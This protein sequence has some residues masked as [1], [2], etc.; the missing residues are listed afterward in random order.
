MKK[1]YLGL[2]GL[3]V[4]LL[5][6]WTNPATSQTVAEYTIP[7]VGIPITPT[8]I[9]IQWGASPNAQRCWLFRKEKDESDWTFGGEFGDPNVTAYQDTILEGVY[10]EYMIA[11]NFTNTNNQTNQV[12]F[13]FL[14]TGINYLKP[15]F[16]GQVI[17]VEDSLSTVGL[18]P[19][20]DR[21]IDDLHG[22]G[23]C[24]KRLKCNGSL[25]NP[26]AI[27]TRIQTLYNAAPDEV[28]TVVLLGRVPVPYSGDINP[29]AHAD[30][31]GA[32][33][34]D[35]YYGDMTGTWTDNTVN[36]I[37]AA[38]P[39]NRN[40]PG[41]GKF[42]PSNYPDSI[43]LGVGRID[44]ANMPLFGT[45]QDLLRRYLNKNHDYRHRIIN[46]VRRALVD[47]NF[48]ML[49]GEM[50][51]AGT[52]RSFVSLMPNNV[53]TGDFFPTLATTPH[54][55][56][57]GSGGGSYT[58]AGG[59]GTSTDFNTQTPQSVFTFLFG[60]YFGD[61]DSP[62][63]NFLRAPLASNGWGLASIWAGRPYTVLHHMG[64]GDEI[65]YSLRMPQRYT[66]A[67]SPYQLTLIT[68][69]A[70]M[71]HIGL[72]GDPTLRMHTVA[73]PTNVVATLQD[74]N[75]RVRLNW[76]ASVD[77][78][79]AGYI[80]F[81][82]DPATGCYDLISG[83]Q[84]LTQT[85]FVDSFPNACQNNK[86]MVRVAKLELLTGRWFNWSQG[87][88]GS[89][90][91][92]GQPVTIIANP[93]TPICAG[94][95]VQLTA[96]GATTYSWM[97]GSLTGATIPVNPT[98]TTTYTVVGTSGNCTSSATITVTV[99]NAP[100]LTN[101]TSNS[102]VCEGQSIDFVIMGCTNCNSFSWSGPGGFTSTV[103]NATRANVLPTHS[104]NYTVTITGAGGC[105][106][107]G[108]VSVTVT[109]R[110]T[111]NVTGTPSLTIC[112]GQTTQLLA[113][114]ATSYTWLPATGLSSTTIANPV[115]NPT[116][117]T[118]YTV[119]GTTGNC[120]NTT[121]VTVTI[122]S[123]LNI[124]ANASPGQTI[125]VGQSTTLT[126]SGGTTYTWMPGNL[127]GGTVNVSPTSTTTYTVVGNTAGCTGTATI[128]ITVNNGLTVNVTANPGLT[129][130]PNGSTTLTATG[131]TEYV[132]TPPTGLSSTTIANPVAN[133][134]STT[135]YTVVGNTGGC[136]GTAVVT[137]TV[138]AGL[139]VGITSNPGLT[140]CP[141]G[142]TVLTATGATSYVWSNGI[143]TANNTITT[144][145]T[146]TVT[147]TSN[148]CTAT[149]SATV[150][151][152]PQM[153]LDRTVTQP[154]CA[155]NNG[156]INLT[157][158]GG[159]PT[160]TYSWTRD[161]NA[162]ST[163]EDLTGL[164]AGVYA[165]TVR[166]A[167]GCT[168]TLSV[169]L[170]VPNAPIA[171]SQVTNVTCNGGN[172][173][174]VNLTVTGGTPGYTFNWT[175][176]GSPAGTTEDQ[177]NALAGTYVVTVTDQA[178]CTVIHTAIVNQPAAILINGT[179]T[180]ITCSGANNGAINITVTGG[181]PGYTFNW[182][183]NGTAFA[184][185][186][187]LTGLSA[188]TYA[189]TVTDQA[190]CTATRSSVI[191]PEPA[192]LSVTVDNFANALCGQAVG[193]ISITIAGGTPN[194]SISWTKDGNAFSTQEDLTN[195]LPGVYAVSVRD[196]NGCTV[197]A[198]ITI[199]G[200]TGPSITQTVVVQPTCNNSNNGSITVTV[201]GGEAPLT[202]QWTKDGNNFAATQNITGLGAG[203]YVLTVKDANG[204][205]ATTSSLTIA[206]PA[207]VSV[208]GTFTNPTCFGGTNG[209]ITINVTGGTTPYTFNWTRNGNAFAT[210]QNITN[211]SAGTYAVTVRDANNC[212][213][214]ANFTLTEPAQ[215]TVTV[216]SGAGTIC[217]GGVSPTILLGGAGV[218]TVVRWERSTDNFATVTTV[219][220]TLPFYAP[221]PL[222]VTTCF[223][224]VLTNAGCT[225][226]STSACVTA[227]PQVTAGT[228]NSS[229][230][231]CQNTTTTL[232]LTGFT[233]NVI[234]WETS[235]D[236]VSWTTISNT[237]A[238]YVLTNVTADIRVRVQVGNGF[239]PPVYSNVAI[240]T[241]TPPP[242][243]GFLTSDATYCEGDNNDVLQL[244]GQFGTIVRWESS[245]NNFTSIT[246]I[247]NT[248]NTQTYSNLT[249]TTWF[250][251]VVGN[252][253]CPLAYSNSVM[254]TIY[255]AP[256]GGTVNSSI[257]VCAGANMGTLNLTGYAGDILQ[258]ESSTDNFFTTQVIPNNT[259]TL[260]YQNVA[261]TT[262][263]RA[264]VGSMFCG[265]A[266]STEAEITVA[267]NASGGTLLSNMTVCANNNGGVLTLAGYSGPILRWEASLDNFVTMTTI[268]NTTPNFTYSNVPQT[269][270]FRAVVGGIGNCPTVY[271][272]T[273]KLTA[274]NTAMA[275]ELTAIQ[276][277]GSGPCASNSGII[278]MSGHSGTIIR[279]E[280]S[281]DN[282]TNV[283]IPITNITNV[284]TYNVSGVTQYRAVL[285]NSPCPVVYSAPVTVAGGL[286]VNAVALRECNGRGKIV[287]TA[288]GGTLPY[289]Y[290]ISPN[291]GIQSPSGVFYNLT[292][293]TY[294]VTVR[295]ANGC[296][297]TR[298]VT[299]PASL[300]GPAITA[301][302]PSGPTQMRVDW[303][304]V[305]PGGNT[306]YYQL[307]YRPTGGTWTT[308]N[309]GSNTTY[310]IT[311]LTP[312][313]SY[314]VQVRVRCLPSTI[315]SSW[316]ATRTFQMRS[317][318]V[319]EVESINMGDVSLYPN[320]NNGNFTLRFTQ[321]DAP[322]SV[323]LFDMTGRMVYSTDFSPSE[324]NDA[325]DLRLDVAKGIYNVQIMQG[326]ISKTVKVVIE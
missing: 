298:K 80:V 323:R 32:W 75:T 82:L 233:G 314:E 271:S 8:V 223:R 148:N 102:P 240:I 260:T 247:A 222:T 109:A 205:Q 76:T 58:S 94:Q 201:T 117:T 62:S 59:I 35:G 27:R 122:S 256:N 164:G 310:I 192:E 326:G 202:Y 235:P 301:T 274:V 98:S 303:I 104:G 229:R 84:A 7:V 69:H 285:Q 162:F 258:W 230:T 126:A 26:P 187:D 185:Q 188:G 273:I 96:S 243:G 195:L 317:D 158:T 141:N 157:A 143:T 128:T 44:F 85:T 2:V 57:Y 198:N 203:I 135:T 6:L 103:Q 313:T 171:S 60:S 231:I 140:I 120:T 321:T 92:P 11:R 249:R 252:G 71:V 246:T 226:T 275:G 17:V 54:L 40:A 22:D 154:T 89:I 100:T 118:T 288:A 318:A 254:I 174:G 3:I 214:T 191:N 259:P 278:T 112:T 5:S 302:V 309:V 253:A 255:P 91:V 166:D 193:S 204:C 133:P 179:P 172:N 25:D 220:N 132:W 127:T 208:M 168:A 238:T 212:T 95:T 61:W 47:D 34:A 262:R 28:T 114:G 12:A 297:A 138:G 160:L 108:M 189:V 263:Y 295:D 97:P 280:M 281:T 81:R 21:F 276:T 266:Y 68:A 163:Q 90:T 159:T 31:K 41:D 219:N 37:T 70:K 268:A 110:P 130:C 239:C 150:V 165:V 50:P 294:T 73:P 279:W 155:G 16:N 74:N 161:G 245:T 125:C 289:T 123:G 39:R 199:T 106:T 67:S 124:S 137:V 312:G 14:A 48:G 79:L 55:M 4:G 152:S 292:P 181:T 33:P 190:G 282:F 197:M 136:T 216:G 169:T 119:T 241:V 151:V 299:I 237:T 293:T 144:A 272:N 196:A 53:F 242:S 51:G 156:A 221:G 261:Q 211:A 42:D 23:W 210:T 183:R 13:G 269:T 20:V 93:N 86:Y 64:L 88:F 15:I 307:R 38:D 217:S 232:N 1:V 99:N 113:T 149:A 250:R 19:E 290:F 170:S 178:G 207:A 46:P 180:Q 139:N 30:H 283:I 153:I 213:G 52:L 43:R 173:G 184:T 304:D 177:T 72:M 186:E 234:R 270:W 83:N 306:V 265:M 65:G 284:Y 142:T 121:T 134:T 248:G 147:G 308:K 78:S 300:T 319:S 146:Y 236:G 218:G 56:S 244:T 145:G 101:I 115:A 182:T 315:Y 227:V 287:A 111:M 131:A 105:T 325:L 77:T 24:V 167:V 36:N 225:V 206:N 291:G 277:G 228:L 116:S 215:P 10:Y 316:S 66:T 257:T 49:S 305:A 209:T 194:Y 264:L 107:T 29:D 251:A 224:A 322:A 200:T 9:R 320:P 175:R 296:T 311:G 267:P 45:Q 63:N 87:N 129:I 324:S 18:T 286:V 176:D